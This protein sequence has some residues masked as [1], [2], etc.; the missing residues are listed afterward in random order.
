MSEPPLYYLTLTYLD[1]FTFGAIASYL[2][3][4]NINSFLTKSSYA[5]CFVLLGLIFLCYTYEDQLWWP[6]YSYK[7]VFSYGLF[8]AAI[9]FLILNLTINPVRKGSY[10]LR[11]PFM[12]ILGVLSFGIYLWHPLVHRIINIQIAKMDFGLVR[13]NEFYYLLIFF[14][15]FSLAVLL[16][17]L[18]VV[19]FVWTSQ[20][21]S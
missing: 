20:R 5:F 6:P 14:E 18:E 11:T 9:S 7:T 3:K 12:K 10:I 21:Q 17:A 19:P 16:S 13:M 8:S 2:Y 1:A 4:K 15:Y